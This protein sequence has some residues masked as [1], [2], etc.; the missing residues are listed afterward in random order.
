MSRKGFPSLLLTVATLVSTHAWA[1]APV[2]YEVIHTLGGLDGAN[3]QSGLVKG[4]D[5]HLYGTATE[6]GADGVGTI[7]RIEAD[8]TFTVIHTFLASAPENGINPV[9]LIRGRDKNLYGT[10]DYGGTISNGDGNPVG[11]GL[12]YRL[13]WNG[14]TY[15][16][17]TVIHEFDCSQGE[18]GDPW[19]SLIEGPDG[20]LYGMTI[21]SYWPDVDCT[22]GSTVFKVNKDGSGFV[23]LAA[24]DWQVTGSFQFG[25]LAFGSDGSVFG[26]LESRDPFMGS[27]AG[28]DPAEPFEF[29]SVFKIDPN[30]VVTYP[31]IFSGTD[32]TFPFSGLVRGIDGAFYGTTSEG[33]A[34][35]AGTIFRIDEN[36]GF[37]TLH[38]FDPAS[39][40]T[41]YSPLVIG[42]DQKIYGAAHAGGASD[43][44]GTYI[45]D[46]LLPVESTGRFIVHSIFDFTTTGS[47]PFGPIGVGPAPERHLYGTQSSGGANSQGT[48]FGL[49]DIQVVNRP[50]VPVVLA[51]PNPAQAQSAAGATVFL[52]ALG[53]SDADFDDLTYSWTL[54][55]EATD[56]DEAEDSSTISATFPPGIW[57]V[58]L[59]VS[60]GIDSPSI[61]VSVTVVDGPPTFSDVD[62]IAVPATTSAGAV[63]TYAEPTATDIV[64]G[65]RPVTC[66]PPSGDTFPIGTTTVVCSASDASGNVGTTSFDVTVTES[67]VLTLPEDVTLEAT[68][69]SGAAFAFT[70]AATGSVPGL[71]PTCLPALAVFP[72]GTTTVTCTV[73]DPSLG[74]AT[75]SFTVTVVD[76]TAPRI[77]LES[78][79]EFNAIGPGLSPAPYVVAAA[80]D[81]DSSVQ[82]VCTPP[83]GNFPLGVTRV[84]CEAEDDAGN[85]SALS[86]DVAV[87]DSD[88]P[89]LT[90]PASFQV[91][92]QGPAGALVTYSVSASDVTSPDGVTLS[93]SPASNTAFG[94][95]VTTVN[96]TAT[97]TSGHATTR[98]FTVTVRDTTAPVVAVANVIVEATSGVGAI[99]S[100]PLPTATD[101]VGVVGPITCTRAPGSLFAI[102]VTPVTCE[103][104]DAAGNVG[105]GAFTVTVRDTTAPVITVPADIVVVTTDPDG[106]PVTYSVSALDAVDGVTAVSC[107][108][109]SGFT[110]PVAVT[111]VTCESTDSRGNR[112]TKTF[113]VAVVTTPPTLVVSLTPGVLW[114]PNHKMVTINATITATS[115]VGPAPIV[116]LVS[117]TSNEPDNGLGDGDT[118]ND[119]Q[120]A[121]YGT[122]DRVFQLRAERSGKGNGRIYTVTY[123]ATSPLNPSIFTI[124]QG[125]VIVPHD[126]SGKKK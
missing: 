15:S 82:L 40:H 67:L 36:G 5:G 1:Q 31:R 39:I 32:G 13:N 95:G 80:D 2:P 47:S 56:V 60:D 26:T 34:N 48:L 35:G 101:A 109:A 44:G 17:I 58:A 121:S 88:F 99:V 105:S 16:G 89:V 124:V 65:V 62:D 21:P 96:C 77:T 70:A 104:R 8:G 23:V 78:I 85:Q 46:P 51:S 55:P 18:G 61:T 120:E 54:P 6:G 66:A 14:T 75:D 113:T 114:P 97:D 79:T 57:S 42:G 4:A 111:T 100:F 12:I 64:D 38:S 112:S 11:D 68:S 102:G 83:P 125:T 30:G 93:C 94:L 117:I 28:V 76:T 123:K 90:V 106:T 59:T 103:A 84:T 108:P 37:T 19:G 126:M 98:S 73:V 92:A 63:V 24:F 72:L 107:S 69:P 29:G 91:E 3:P 9:S 20:A 86:F 110:F 43:A 74:T 10:T 33:G 27:I 49:L 119:I 22:R 52:S 81:V 25:P 71:E 53:S 87:R 118:V 115:A 122:N 41:P 116:T 45:L 7:Y 50:P